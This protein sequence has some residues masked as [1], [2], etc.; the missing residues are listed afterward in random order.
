V[1]GL[2]SYANSGLTV[3]LRTEYITKLY[4]FSRRRWRRDLSGKGK[5]YRK[6]AHMREPRVFRSA[7]MV[8]SDD[9]EDL[10]PDCDAAESGSEETGD[11][12]DDTNS[13]G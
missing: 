9:D 1:S 13:E 12:M 4:K 10:E 8:P 11:G 5:R 2:D 3:H 6:P 7:A